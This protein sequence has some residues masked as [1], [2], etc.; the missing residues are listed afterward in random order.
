MPR[1]R[2]R[3]NP[4]SSPQ[5]F[6]TDMLSRVPAISRLPPHVLIEFVS[7][8]KPY[9]FV[10]GRCKGARAVRD[11]PRTGFCVR[12]SLG[13]AVTIS[14]NRHSAKTHAK[15][16]AFT[17]CPVLVAMSVE[18]EHHHIHHADRSGSL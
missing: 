5:A 17:V 9:Y 18:A 8:L 11:G 3:P 10:E 14:A 16:I 13:V 7:Q 1:F 12:G 4:C 15:H 2:P 6:H